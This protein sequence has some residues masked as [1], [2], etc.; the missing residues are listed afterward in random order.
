MTNPGAFASTG[1]PAGTGRLIATVMV[2]GVAVL[3]DSTIVAV[4]LKSLAADLGTSVTTI[5]WVSTAYLLAVGVSIPLAAWAQSRWGGRAL[6]LAGLVVFGVGSVAA[7]MAGGVGMLIAAR[8]LQGMGGGVL[9]PLMATLPMQAAHGRVNA[10]QVALVTLPLLIGPML[11]PVIGGVILNWLDWRWLFWVNVPLIAIGF[12]AAWRVLPTDDDLSPRKLDVTGAV[13]LPPGLVGVLFGLSQV[14]GMGGFGHPRVLVPIA[15]GTVLIA[16]FAVHGRR[17]A[18]SLIDVRLLATRPVASASLMMFLTGAA[19]YGGMFLLPLYW[20][21][22]RGDS[23]LMAGLLLMPQGLGTLLTRPLTGRITDAFGARGVALAGVLVVTAAT[24]VF[25]VA[26]PTTSPWLLT[27]TLAVRGVGMGAVLVPI[28][29]VAYHGLSG[30]DVANASV[31]TRVAQ[32][33]GGSFGTALLAVILEHG[34]ATMSPERAFQRSFWW[35]A[36]LSLVSAGV[37]GALPRSDAVTSPEV[38]LDPTR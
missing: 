13:L 6:W 7:S 4:A 35:A 12:I 27:A 8:V 26:T 24:A 30:E 15:V 11:G 18:H 2:G 20:Q 23:V 9:L 31:L 22:G 3:L 16:A 21:L 25:A 29:A 10:R 36:G 33:V 14:S 5:Q 17:T 34:L 32:Q 28:L 37:V 38:E 19:L 1:F